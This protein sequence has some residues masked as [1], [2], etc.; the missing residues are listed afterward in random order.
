MTHICYFDSNDR[1]KYFQL[2]KVKISLILRVFSCY[3]VMIF[4]C[5]HEERQDVMSLG[6]EII[7]IFWWTWERRK[8]FEKE[9]NLFDIKW[10]Y[11]DNEFFILF[12]SP[13]NIDCTSKIWLEEWSM[14]VRTSW[15]LLRWYQCEIHHWNESWSSSTILEL[16]SYF[17]KRGYTR[18]RRYRLLI[19]GT[20]L[21]V[22]GQRVRGS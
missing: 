9:V 14:K 8:T 1:Q 17:L 10:G 16:L 20:R 13:G 6:S 19:F 21:L 12:S 5:S 22:F 11:R 2:R 18:V 4:V 3:M 15:L 7:L